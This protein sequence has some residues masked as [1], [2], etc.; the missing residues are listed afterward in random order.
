V[1][2]TVLGERFNLFTIPTSQD[3]APSREILVDT[4]A[5]VNDEVKRLFIE[6]LTITLALGKKAIRAAF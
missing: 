6:E 3:R 2:L 4:G 1:L 5:V